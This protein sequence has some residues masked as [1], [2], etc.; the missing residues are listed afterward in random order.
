MSLNNYLRNKQKYEGNSILQKDF[1]ETIGRIQKSIS[2]TALKDN[3]IVYRY[4]DGGFAGVNNISELKNLKKGA[5]LKT[6]GFL[7][8][9]VLRKTSFGNIG[10]EIKLKK[11]SK[12]GQYIGGMSKYKSEREFLIKHGA[13]MKVL[14]IKQ[15]GNIPILE[16]EYVE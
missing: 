1:E 11:G 6:K 16:L 4:D 7:S 2:Q 5:I 10:Y 3:L 8:T 15:D 12:A 14:G 9:S 13:K